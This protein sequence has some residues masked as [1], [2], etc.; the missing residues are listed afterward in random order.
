MSDSR[1]VDWDQIHKSARVFDLHAHPALK[2]S[3]FKRILTLN[4]RVGRGFDP[5]AVRA[6]FPKL[7]LGGVDAISSV[8]YAPEKGLL[9]DCRLLRILKW[10]LPTSKDLFADTYFDITMD[11]LN[12]MDST[13]EEARK[14][15]T[16][17]PYARIIRSARELEDSIGKEDGGPIRFIHS[18]EGAHSLDG[19]MENLDT[20]YEKGVASLTLAHFY[21]NEVVTPV[22]PFPE[23]MQRFGCFGGRRDLTKGLTDFGRLVVERMVEL[24][25]L[26]DV[27]HCTPT[28]RREVFDIVDNRSP[29][30]ATHV[31]TYEV[32]PNPYNLQDQEMKAIADSGGIVG[33]I[34]MNSWL[35][36]HERKR[37]IDYILQKT[38]RGDC[39]L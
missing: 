21:V 30:L 37:G 10:F 15:G 4:H 8:I 5:L 28:A 20:L 26:I 39:G 9:E 27:A 23:K 16:D 12:K 36:P 18:V 24:G 29:I 35:A 1:H 3:L 13:I 33:V 7:E 34:F 2:L 32:N 25:M 22:F 31:G 6:D 38:H 19:K 17:K 14:P 11:I